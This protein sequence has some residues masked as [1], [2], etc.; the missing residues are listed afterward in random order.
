MR[1]ALH[2]LIKVVRYFPAAKRLAL[3]IEKRVQRIQ[4][5][6]PRAPPPPPP[7]CATVGWPFAQ[8]S[9]ALVPANSSRA[10][11]LGAAPPRGM[12]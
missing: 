11:A 6:R 10:I 1:N 4:E 7:L 3:L 12:R 5:V 9:A 8:L 2:V